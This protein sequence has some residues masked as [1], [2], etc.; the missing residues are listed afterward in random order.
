MNKSLLLVDDADAL[1]ELLGD[2]IERRGMKVFQGR[3]RRTG[4]KN[5]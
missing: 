2:A 1:R 4:D 5:F 3:Y